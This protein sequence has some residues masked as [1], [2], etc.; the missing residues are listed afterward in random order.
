MIPA[1][2]IVFERHGADFLVATIIRIHDRDAPTI[3][4]V[5]SQRSG[6]SY[7]VTWREGADEHRIRVSV[8]GP[9]MVQWSVE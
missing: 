4:H 2:T 1:P 5:S 7:L 6:N 8:R 9:L 3:Q